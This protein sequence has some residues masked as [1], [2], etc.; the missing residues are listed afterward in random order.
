MFKKRL[1]DFFLVIV[2]LQRFILII[3]SL[4]IVVGLGITVF[5]RYFIQSDLFGLEELLLIPAL[6][7]Y[8][9]GASFGAYDKYHVTADL[10]NVYLKNPF[11]KRVILIIT[12]TVTLIVSIVML[13]WA[14]EFII[15]SVQSGAKS[16]AWKIPMYIP[17]SS[18]L[19]G[20]LLM[21]LYFA[22]DFIEII[23]KDNVNSSKG[24]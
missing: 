4:A 20:F 1:S 7:L 16:S 11:I 17:Q 19:F 2:K 3:S 23:M 6:W 15:W 12:T 10:L 9:I 24:D 8:F 13:V 5:M 22:R 14:F 21:T 18:V